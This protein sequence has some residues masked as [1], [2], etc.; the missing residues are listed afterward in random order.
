[1]FG[2]GM[3]CL[4]PTQPEHMHEWNQRTVVDLNNAI[5]S[6]SDHQASGW[7]HVHVADVVFPLVER[8]QGRSTA[9]QTHTRT[10][11]G[12]LISCPFKV[13]VQLA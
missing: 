7:V 4:P 3:I 1:M 6:T 12:H 2:F 13:R 8:R 11:R 9:K 10:R 5:A